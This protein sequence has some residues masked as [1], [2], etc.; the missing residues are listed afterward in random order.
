[1]RHI[2]AHKVGMLI[3][4]RYVDYGIIRIGKAYALPFMEPFFLGNFLV[5]P[6]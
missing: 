3:M 1:M 6:C 5:M 4:G 2:A